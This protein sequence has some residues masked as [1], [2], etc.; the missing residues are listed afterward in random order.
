MPNETPMI[1][2]AGG[3]RL[4]DSAH[5]DL[6]AAAGLELDNLDLH[7]ECDE[8]PIRELL[9]LLRQATPAVSE[10]GSLTTSAIIKAAA[11]AVSNG[12]TMSTR[13]SALKPD[14]LDPIISSLVRIVES[15]STANQ[16]GAANCTPAQLRDF[17]LALANA[18]QDRR[19]ATRRWARRHPYRV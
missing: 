10:H 11:S 13:T 17:C 9:E 15:D 7:G 8:G 6:A 19:L 1:P 2:D 5:S 3:V 18:I 12:G 14:E 16:E 4:L